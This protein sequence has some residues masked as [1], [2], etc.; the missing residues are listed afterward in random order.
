MLHIHGKGKTFFTTH[1]HFEK[2]FHAICSHFERHFRAIFSIYAHGQGTR[3]PIQHMYTLLERC[4]PLATYSNIHI[5][6]VNNIFTSSR[7]KESSWY[8][9]HQHALTFMPS[10]IYKL[11]LGFL[12]PSHI[13]EIIL[14]HMKLPTHSKTA[15]TCIPIRSMGYISQNH[16]QMPLRQFTEHLVG[17][18]LGMNNKG[19]RTM[20]HAQL[21]QNTT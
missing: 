15:I 14:A 18:C 21:F 3:L 10:Y 11:K 4:L 8:N 19:I 20:S 17:A 16:A 9:P 13:S 7:R 12:G 2:Q 5:Y 6:I 1:S